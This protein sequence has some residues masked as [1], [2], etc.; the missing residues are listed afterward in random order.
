MAL[1]KFTSQANFDVLQAVR[2]LAQ[3]E[4]KPL[5]VLLNEALV[6]LLAK[7]QQPAF[8]NPAVAQHFEQSLAQYDDVYRFLAQ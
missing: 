1:K 3:A 6:D 4:G 7:R 5:R 8:T 2:Q